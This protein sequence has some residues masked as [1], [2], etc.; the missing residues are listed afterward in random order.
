VQGCKTGAKWS[1]LYTE[2]PRA[3]ASGRLDLRSECFVTRIEHDDA[4]RATGVVYRD[5]AGVE[6]RQRA[7]VVCVA[8][9]AIETARLLLL[10]E[11]GYFKHGLA[12]GSD[13]VGRNYC[14]HV[15][16]F[17]FGVFDQPVSFWR[18]A[19]L[20]GVVEDE[21]LHDPR[22]GFAG[23]YHLELAMVDLP[24]L[25]LIG[26]PYGWGRD[27]A[28]IIDNYRNMAGMLVNGEDLPRADNRI[29]LSTT[30]KD[31]YGL[32]VAH[33]HCEP[34]ANDMAMRAHAT[35]QGQKIYEA[36][37]A[38][39][40]V[41]SSVPPATHQMGTARMSHDPGQGVTNP[42]GRTHEVPNLFISDGSVQ[43]TAGAA[44]PTLTIVALV[45]RQA[46]H[47]GREA[48]AGRL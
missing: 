13:Q 40:T 48:A 7:R 41:V 32:P 44:N 19:V 24:T 45:L 35:G 34:H 14:H 18:G 33:I 1:T 11:S 28:S 31:A 6:Q 27:F 12:N 30:R 39:R 36:V 5:A 29:T 8:G 16:S 26:L 17:V 47:I 2:I 37:G 20:A 15:L 42:Y 4:G 21:N 43:T 9:N 38:K 22:R 3:E 10:S 25:P 46:E 23:G